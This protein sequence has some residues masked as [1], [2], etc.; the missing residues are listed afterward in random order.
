M[1]SFC[2]FDPATMPSKEDELEE[3]GNDSVNVLFLHFKSL[4]KETALEEILH[5]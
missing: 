5:E 3:F 1:A 4:M 2:V